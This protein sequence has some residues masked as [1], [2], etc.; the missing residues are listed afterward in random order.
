MRRIA[1]QEPRIE[2]DELI[3]CSSLALAAAAVLTVLATKD[4]VR[5][6]TGLEE[7]ERGALL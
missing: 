1:L 5:L 3:A 2:L 4:A 7:A 6:N